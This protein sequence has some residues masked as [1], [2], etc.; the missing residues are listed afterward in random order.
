MEIFRTAETMR[1]WSLERKC[2]GQTI[3]FV[4]TMGALH[5]GHLSLM[6]AAAAE[7]DV[8]VASIFVNPT[9]FAPNEDF[10]AYPRT[11]ERDRELCESV[12]VVAIYAPTASGMYPE[13]Y[14]TYVAVEKLTN[15]LCSRTRPHFFR[16]V[17]TVVTKLF[18]AVLPDRAYFGQKDA[19]QCAVIKRMARDL[20]MGIEIIE[21]PIV[22]DPDGMAMSSRNQYLGPEDR[23]RGL[24]LSRSLFRAR[25]MLERGERSAA[26]IV[27][28]VREG[29]CD[30]D[31]DYVE[32]VDTETIPPVDHIEHEILLAVAAQVGPARLID[33]IKFTPPEA[34]PRDIET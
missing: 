14:A 19:Q 25:D 31:I 2:A 32:L 12:G 1:A 17:A 33:N 22:R 13:G 23:R 16:G 27:A 24:C 10:D 4:P 11:F 6:R 34:A 30:V 28:A 20:D 9:Q 21:M 26:K 5:E 15:G 7:N 18:N 3:G 8:A 29:M